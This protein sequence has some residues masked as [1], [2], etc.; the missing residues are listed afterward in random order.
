MA[1]LLSLLEKRVRGVAFVALLT[2]L[3]LGAMAKLRVDLSTA[4]GLAKPFLD[5]VERGAPLVLSTYVRRVHAGFDVARAVGPVVL[6]FEGAYDSRAPV[7]R[8]DFTSPLVPVATGVVGLEWQPGDGDTFVLLE[9]SAQQLLDLPAGRPLLFVSETTLS[10]GALVRHTFREH[11][12]FELRGAAVL[13]PRSYVL[14]PQIAWKEAAWDLR[15]G[16]VWLEGD[17]NSYARYYAR[18]AQ[19]FLV[20]RGKF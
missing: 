1:F 16:L 2:A 5:S 6:K 20:G 14:R 13:D 9:T 12:E 8:D 18:N 4:G 7:L 11:L 15:A 10:Q 17:D 19:A 3:A